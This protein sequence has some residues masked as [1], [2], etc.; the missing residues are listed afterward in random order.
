MKT[1]IA[2]N[3]Y[4]D[5]SADANKNRIYL[6]LSGFWSDKSAVPDYLNDVSKSIQNVAPGF[7]V[8]VDMREFKTATEEITSIQKQ[9][10]GMLV[11]AGLERTAEVLSQEMKIQQITL[12]NYGKA[13]GMKKMSFHD[14]I[15]ATKWLDAS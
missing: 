11:Q 14:E 4:Y 8:L 7:T 13:S 10:G 6:T 15:E 3:Q 1:T 5:I 12:E 2:K 9:A